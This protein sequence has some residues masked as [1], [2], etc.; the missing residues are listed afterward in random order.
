LIVL[1]YIQIQ[2]FLKREAKRV[3]SKQQRALPKTHNSSSFLSLLIKLTPERDSENLNIDGL[4]FIFLYFSLAIFLLN[5]N[6]KF[7]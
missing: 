4:F 5:K 3:S 7:L 2:I 1:N 6:T